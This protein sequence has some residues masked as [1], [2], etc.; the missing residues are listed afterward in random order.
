MVQDSWYIDGLP[1]QTVRSKAWP[2]LIIL[3][4]QALATGVWFPYSSN[5]RKSF[6][7]QTL[8][9]HKV[10]QPRV[11]SPALRPPP[12]RSSVCPRSFVD[13]RTGCRVLFSVFTPRLSFFSCLCN[14]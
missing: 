3:A 12:A 10:A 14:P 8:R 1:G 5:R 2:L 9:P 13:L 6:G 7:K 4:V 11:L